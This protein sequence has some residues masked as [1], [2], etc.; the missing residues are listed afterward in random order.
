MWTAVLKE[1]HTIKSG[2][3]RF[4]EYEGTAMGPMQ[5]QVVDE[6]IFQANTDS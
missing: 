6:C 1:F 2:G 5:A 3:I 4:G